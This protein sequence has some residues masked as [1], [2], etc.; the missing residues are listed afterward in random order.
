MTAATA[1]EHSKASKGWHLCSQS[2][3]A[4]ASTPCGSGVKVFPVCGTLMQ[5]GAEVWF[6]GKPSSELQCG[7]ECVNYMVT[8]KPKFSCRKKKKEDNRS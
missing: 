8:R 4:N 5:K 7:Q 6:R 2:K 3:Q 1:R